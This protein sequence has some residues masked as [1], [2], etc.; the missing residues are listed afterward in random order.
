MLPDANDG[1][2]KLLEEIL[3][4]HQFLRFKELFDKSK[5]ESGR[6]ELHLPKFKLGG[7]ESLDMK[8]PLSAMGVESVFSRNH[9]DFSRITEKER[10][11]ISTVVHQAV[12][13]ASGCQF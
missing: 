2:L 12:I 11:H 1:L 7:V 5:Y 6:V 8:E 13:E 9:A 4:R 3:D 10:L